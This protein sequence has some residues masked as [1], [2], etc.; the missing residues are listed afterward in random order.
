MGE[1]IHYSSTS[2]KS[3]QYQKRIYLQK[4]WYIDRK[5]R[6][7]KTYKILRISNVHVYIYIYLYTVFYNTGNNE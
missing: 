3:Q 2:P 7:L 1:R 5:C 4:F 6:I